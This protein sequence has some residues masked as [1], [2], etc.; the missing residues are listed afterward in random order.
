MTGGCYLEYII[1]LVGVG[2]LA[3]LFLKSKKNGQGPAPAGSVY[4]DVDEL[5]ERS[6]INKT[7]SSST[8]PRT[9]G[10]ER[11]SNAKITVNQWLTAGYPLGVA[12]AALTN[13]DY[14][15][16]TSN[17][18]TGD[19]GN[20]FGLYQL[21][22]RG[23]GKG[24]TESQMRDPVQN[25]LAIMR[26]Y[27]A[28]NGDP[29]DSAMRSGATLAQMAGLFGKYVERPAN[30]DVIELRAAYCRKLFPS[31]ANVPGKDLI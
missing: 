1:P 29:V 30:P 26:D 17:Y 16:R 2:T 11:V 22:V 5:I 4:V 14:E 20:S 31:I 18:A 9:K 3:W 7:W 12:L 27:A 19:S 6:S 8:I 15:S 10:S 28:G 23:A 25:T 13:A 24:M 21:H